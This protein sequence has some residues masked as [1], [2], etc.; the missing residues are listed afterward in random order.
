MGTR[1][2]NPAERECVRTALQRLND[3]SPNQRD[4]ARRI[5]VSQQHISLILN[6][7]PVGPG[8]TRKLATYLGM[9]FDDL[10]AG[11]AAPT[12]TAAAPEAA[13]P[14]PP[15]SAAMGRPT[16]FAT[17]DNERIREAVRTLVAAAG[18]QAAVARTLDISGGALSQLLRGKTGASLGLTSRIADIAGLP[19]D[20]FIRGAADSLTGVRTFT[21]PTL[22]REYVA[23]RGA[24][25]DVVDGDGDTLHSFE[26]R[27][28]M[29]GRVVVQLLTDTSREDA[30]RMLDKIR[31]CIARTP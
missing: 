12:P 27:A 18:S 21:P 2:L 16:S 23:R 9:T 30:L 6:K 7:G 17:E 4:L 13:V 22:V 25:Y 31:A 24:A 15:R 20:A 28:A 11:K 8:S 3:E 5:G 26:H 19:L 10:V 1:T 14:S 29:S